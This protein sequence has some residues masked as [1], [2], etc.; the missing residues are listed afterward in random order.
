MRVKDLP[1]ELSAAPPLAITPDAFVLRGGN[2]I[3]GPDGKYIVEPVFEE[4]AIITAELD[5]NAV[6]REKMTLD[7]SGFTAG[8]MFSI[9]KFGQVNAR[10]Q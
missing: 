6:D 4:E 8:R 5:L 3:I 9:S 2:A 1:N 7:V 10:A